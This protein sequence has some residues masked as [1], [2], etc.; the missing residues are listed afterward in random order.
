MD[1]FCHKL[2]Q[3]RATLDFF[4]TS[5]LLLL[6]EPRNS[7]L[8]SSFYSPRILFQTLLLL[9]E[10]DL[11]RKKPEFYVVV[12]IPSSFSVVYFFSLITKCF[13]Y[14]CKDQRNHLPLGPW[15]KLTFITLHVDCINTSW[16]L[17]RLSFTS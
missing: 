17:P 8:W 13:L 15:L 4:F 14:N 3:R 2:W 12:Q 6:Q 11:G 5:I 9:A 1:A 7:C 10:W 16:N